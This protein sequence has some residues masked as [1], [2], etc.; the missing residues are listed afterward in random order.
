[1]KGKEEYY[2][3]SPDDFREYGNKLIEWASEYLKNIGSYKVLPDIE[4]G[5]IK[6]QLPEHPNYTG[7]D[8]N[9]IIDDFNKIIIP[10]ITHWNHPGF[11]AYFNSTAS[12]PGILAELLIATLNVNGMLWKT[13]PSA[14][15]LEEVT[16]KWLREMLGLPKNMWGIIYDTASMSSLHAIACAREKLGLDIRE[17]G[18]AGNNFPK[19]RL[20]CSE[21]AHSSIEKGAI[22]LGVGRDGVTK[23]GS[24]SQFRMIPELLKE[25][26]RKDKEQGVLPFCVVATVGTTSTTSIDPV[27]A[28]GEICRKENIWLHVDSA[29]AGITA[30]IPEMR[31]IFDGIE[32]VDSI[33]VNPHKWMFVP[34]D[35]SVLFVREPE[36][37]KRAFSLEPEY[38]KTKVDSE[39]INY[40]DYGVQLGRRFRSLKLWFV[41]KYFGVDGLAGIIKRNIETG[42][43]FKHLIERDS[44]FEIMAPA[45]FSTVCFRY[46]PSG[47]KGDLNILNNNL[48]DAI[49]KTGRILLS[50]TKLNGNFVIRLVVSGIRTETEHILEAWEIIKNIA[51]AIP[52]DQ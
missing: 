42:K 17:K 41:I 45:P 46:N 5:A 15:E 26:I 21:H 30:I 48:M 40:N 50:H 3:M 31:Y 29:H 33:V 8:F 18:L 23:I 51:H 20:Y 49:N 2:D 27:R 52:G 39:V 25:E 13:S 47:Y 38:L 9:K 16:T 14:S 44:D 28:I 24:D 32:Y 7:E 10:G 37:L 12:V 35:C 1:M 43:K 6:A 22:T 19:L 11:M 36:I 34:V 4:P